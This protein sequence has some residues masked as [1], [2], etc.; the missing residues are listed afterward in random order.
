V[1]S[2]SCQYS[3]DDGTTIAK[4]E[5]LHVTEASAFFVVWKIKETKF[6]AMTSMH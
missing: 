3:V 2:L 4:V 6:T 1:E 5:W